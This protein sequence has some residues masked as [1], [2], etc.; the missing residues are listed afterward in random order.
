MAPFSIGQFVLGF[1]FSKKKKFLTDR[2]TVSDNCGNLLGIS[3]DVNDNTVLDIGLVSNLNSLDISS[4]DSIVPNW[5]SISEM[6]ST[7]HVS[8]R[9]N[10]I[11]LSNDGNMSSESHD[12]PVSINW[13]REKK[14]RK[15]K[16]QK[17]KN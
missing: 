11:A 12:S 16:N 17:K 9:R 13:T 15:Q 3:G 14:K 10:K 5:N 8:A 4:D 1:V 6:N 7:D 2:N